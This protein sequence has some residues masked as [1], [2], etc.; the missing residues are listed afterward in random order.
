[1]REFR[2]KKQYEM[3]VEEFGKERVKEK[4]ERRL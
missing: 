4:E 2:S 3:G 1:V